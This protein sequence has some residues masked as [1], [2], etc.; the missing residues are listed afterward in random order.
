MCIYI[1][2]CIHTYICIYTYIYIYIYNRENKAARE[3]R[4]CAAAAPGL[5]AS[6]KVFRGT[7]THMYEKG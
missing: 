5:H 6:A 1:Y 7:I 2:M 4:P 3:P